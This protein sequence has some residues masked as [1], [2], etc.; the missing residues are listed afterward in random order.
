[1]VEDFLSQKGVGFVKKDVSV[2]TSAAQELV[3]NTGQMGVPVTIVN[4]QTIVGFDKVKL[5][6][7]LSKKQR[8]FF[9]ASV[10]DASKITAKQGSGIIIGAYVGRVKPSSPAQR[11]GLIA[12]DI[13]TELNM[14]NIA[15]ATDFEKTVS[16]VSKGSR[17][18]I[19]F[20]RRDKKISMDGTF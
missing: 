20:L 18:S 3:S 9:G 2:D 16:K 1:M 14:Q 17:F 13:I 8:P 12:G 5:E 7:A 11:A 10:A 4:G 6:E 19:V 15:N